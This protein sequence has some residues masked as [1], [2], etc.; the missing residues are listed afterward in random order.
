MPINERFS[1]MVVM[2]IPVVGEYTSLTV[3]P[4]LNT[5][6]VIID[7]TNNVAALSIQTTDIIN[8]STINTINASIS[9]L[10]INGNLFSY[11]NI[12]TDNIS[13]NSASI[14]DACIYNLSGNNTFFFF[15]F[16][17]KR[18]C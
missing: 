8:A 15:S 9:N 18:L 1:K 17:F 5:G 4:I 2:P 10:W 16:Y 3:T 6:D 7:D 13:L 12:N 14:T 11:N